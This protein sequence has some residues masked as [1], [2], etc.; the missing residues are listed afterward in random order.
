[1]ANAIL[2]QEAI[3]NLMPKTFG[4]NHSSPKISVKTN[5]LTGIRQR[6]E[7]RGPFWF[8]VGEGVLVALEGHLPLKIEK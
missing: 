8:G 2:P 3:T 6:I 5:S 4:L 1:M 7:N